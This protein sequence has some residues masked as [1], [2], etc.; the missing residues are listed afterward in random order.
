[1][2]LVFIFSFIGISVSVNPTRL[3]VYQVWFKV[4]A[5]V[6]P[7]AGSEN[8]RVL[9][10]SKCIQDVLTALDYPKIKRVGW[11][12]GFP[13]CHFEMRSWKDSTVSN[14]L[15]GILYV[16]KGQVLPSQFFFPGHV[17][18]YIDRWALPY[19]SSFKFH[20]QRVRS[21]DK[22]G[23]GRTHPSSLIDM[24]LFLGNIQLPLHFTRLPFHFKPLSVG[25][26][27]L[28]MHHLKLSFKIVEH[29]RGCASVPEYNNEGES[30][31]DN[32]Y[33]FASSPVR[34][35]WEFFAFP[36]IA[37]IF[38]CVGFW[39]IKTGPTVVMR[40]AGKGYLCLSVFIEIVGLAAS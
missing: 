14:V 38:A 22:S 21:N 24:K 36:A 8:V 16:R 13:S 20:S 39:K 18:D 4:Y 10:S 17:V 33:P 31:Y 25:C 19:I 7:M 23:V 29:L 40:L 9:N 15:E 12:C 37:F 34:H 35:Q 3:A 30:A 1:M 27:P 28:A 32:P 5:I 6:G 2:A 26:A 11:P